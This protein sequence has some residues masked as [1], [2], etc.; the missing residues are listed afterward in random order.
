VYRRIL[1]VNDGSPGA[2]RAVEVALKLA[3]LFAAELHMILVEELPLFPTT[4]LEVDAQKAII[5]RR[6]A[7]L[8]A[9][10][11]RRAVEARVAFRAHVVVGRLV[12]QV[13]QCIEDNQIDLLVLGVFRRSP[14]WEFIFDSAAERLVRSAP[15]ATHMVK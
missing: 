3:G 7:F 10:A 15:C 11:A 2:G 5:D 9:A 13:L 8:A 4:M 6:F 12:E 14:V 1:V